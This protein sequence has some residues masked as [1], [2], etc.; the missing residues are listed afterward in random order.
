M[1]GVYKTLQPKD[2]RYTPYRAH[3]TLVAT[4][5]GSE[6]SSDCKVYAAEHSLKSTYD[7]VQQGIT[8]IDAGN[9]YYTPAFSTTTDGY[10][11]T[12]IHAQLDHL[13]YR[14]YLY[15]SRAAFGGGAAPH[16]QYRDLGYKAKVIS[17]GFKKV[18]EGILPESLQISASGYNIIDDH[19]GN[20]ILNSTDAPDYEDLMSSYT[21]NRHYKF[22]DEGPIGH[23]EQAVTYGSYKPYASFSNVAFALNTDG[24]TI[25]AVFATSS[26]KLSLNGDLRDV[27]NMANSDFAICFKIKRNAA[28]TYDAVVL[29]KQDA[30]VDFTV[31]IDG[32]VS[33]NTN[34]PSQYPYKIEITSAGNLKFSKSNGSRTISMTSTAALSIGTYYN[35]VIQRNGSTF[36][37]Y[38][39]GLS[40]AT[41]TDTFLGTATTGTN[42][43]SSERDCLNSC[44]IFVGN[45]YSNTKPLRSN[46]SYLHFFNRALT[47]TEVSNLNTNS[48][49]FG[50]YCGNVFY[51]LG[52]IVITHPSIVGQTL[53]QVKLRGTVSVREIEAYCTVSPGEFNVSFNRSLQYWNPLHDQFEI[54]SRYTGSLFRPY[55]TTIGLYNNNNELLAVGKLST[56]IQT[57]AKT[58]TTFVVRFDI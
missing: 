53:T 12:A 7:F 28:T 38:L 42:Y 14:D 48:G 24:T 50:N 25:D 54:D 6:V 20:L 11:K 36:T 39:N 55:V 21:F 4:F 41:L 13:F 15:N 29:A 10:Y 27:Y 31:D 16:L 57:S 34:A 2:I 45:D 46:L 47:T 17:F 9:G 40:N 32:N 51:N 58:D 26:L 30:L 23:I 49:W 18:G 33:T 44:G 22:V 19:N 1:S 56:P 43:G 8:N 35:V 3:K 5:D 52:L 37:M